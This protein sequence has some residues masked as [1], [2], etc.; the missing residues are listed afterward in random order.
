MPQETL[1]PGLRHSTRA[2]SGSPLPR[3]QRL[4]DGG[5][6]RVD[7]TAMCSVTHAVSAPAPVGWSPRTAIAM[8]FPEI[9]ELARSTHHEIRAIEAEFDLRE[10][11]GG[12]T[13]CPRQILRELRWRL[14]YTIDTD[15]I[16][17]ALARLRTRAALSSARS[18]V[19]QDA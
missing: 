7:W 11:G 16:R 5:E 14:E 15:G 6:R 12:D 3:E 1:R 9:V 4:G 8:R 18:V 10:A 13:S 2:L 19:P 17:A